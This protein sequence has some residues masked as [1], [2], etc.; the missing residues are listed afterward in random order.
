MQAQFI[1][2]PSKCIVG[3]GQE[4]ADTPYTFNGRRKHAGPNARGFLLPLLPL[5]LIAV[6]IPAVLGLGVGGFS[7][8]CLYFERA[9][10][11]KKQDLHWLREPQQRVLSQTGPRLTPQRRVCNNLG[12][13]LF[14]KLRADLLPQAPALGV[15]GRP[16]FKWRPGEASRQGLIR[17]SCAC[18][19]LADKKCC[20]SIL[21]F[22]SRTPYRYPKQ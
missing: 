2:T 9:S 6:D 3:A 12:L 7:A 14:S 17:E 22:R 1:S 20:G 18:S 16:E 8:I 11:R 15:G 5:D 19:F 4:W 10:A 13:H 21:L